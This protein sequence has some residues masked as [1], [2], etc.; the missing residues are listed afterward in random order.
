MNKAEIRNNILKKR[1]SLSPE[2]IKNKSHKIFLNLVK[3]PEFLNSSDIMFYVSTKSEV[4]T[5]E[6]I[7]SSIMMGKNIFV[8]IILSDSINLVPSRLIDFDRELA[9]GKKGI[10]EPKEE[11]RR[12]FPAK[13]LDLIILPGVA[14]DTEGNRIGRGLGYYDNFLKGVNPST[15]T[16]ALAFEI[17]IVEKI[18]TNEKDVPVNKIITEKRIINSSEYRVYYEQRDTKHRGK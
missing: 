11:Y 16:I 5:E 12:L 17:Q 1:L 9:K 18:P 13:D 7:K 2:E 14:F 4:Q 8:P 15:N 10:F 3:T 6:M